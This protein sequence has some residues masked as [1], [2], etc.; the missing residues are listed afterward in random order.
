MAEK[1]KKFISLIQKKGWWTL[2]RETLERIWCSRKLLIFERPLKKPG[3]GQGLT[4]AFTY[5]WLD[6]SE[7]G[8]LTQLQRDLTV[9][10]IEER[11]LQGDRCFIAE[12]CGKAVAFI[13]VS[14]K[15]V[16]LWPVLDTISPREGQVYRYN[17]KVDPRYRRRGVYTELTKQLEAILWEEGV[18]SFLITIQPR[19]EVVI[20]ASQKSGFVQTGYYFY[21]RRFFWMK[22]EKVLFGKK[23]EILT[24]YPLPQSE[25]WREKTELVSPKPGRK[26]RFLA[27]LG[28]RD[29]TIPFQLLRIRK[30][31]RVLLTGSEREDCLFA[32]LQGLFP[33]RKI[34]HLMTC[35]LW[36][37]EK[38][39]LVYWFKKWLLRAMARSISLFLVWSREECENYSR[40]FGIP[41]EKFA[42]LPHPTSLDGYTVESR[43]GDYIFAGGDSSRDYETL[44]EAVKPLSAPT[45]IVAKQ[46]TAWNGKELPPHVTTRTADPVEFRRLMAGSRLVVL[47]FYKGLLQSAGQQSY[48][49]AMQLKKPV[50][51][52]GV[53]GVRDYMIPEI[54]AIVVPPEDPEALRKAI[55]RV[56]E[57]GPDVKKMVEAAYQRVQEEFSLNHFVEQLLHF[58]EGCYGYC[59]GNR[60]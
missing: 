5:R 43:N 47:P 21:K 14:K 37:Y 26:I 39:P 36:K 15:S 17:A 41:K 53:T 60:I 51:V 57:G 28:F 13:W 30:D 44:L 55:L 11:F 2:T 16:F 1:S 38:N 29:L 34:P 9:E 54:T 32:L 25:L 23:K 12:D 52:S 35:C 31:Y 33:G 18:Q 22:K 8:Q 56:L 27:K 24:T 49:N 19:N 10:K 48:L 42:F 4:E 46:T 7:A 20:R 59:K 6:P 58:T 3:V 45:M 40:Y 50:I